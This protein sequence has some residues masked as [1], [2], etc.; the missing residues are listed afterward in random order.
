MNDSRM[1][2][3]NVRWSGFL[4][5]PLHGSAALVN[6]S[7]VHNWH[8]HSSFL[9]PLGRWVET[10]TEAVAALA[11]TRLAAVSKSPK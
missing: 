8:S 10:S 4:L 5:Y 3:T 2:L 9:N 1:M 11:P 7:S 6:L